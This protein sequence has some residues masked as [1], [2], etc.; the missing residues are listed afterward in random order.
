MIDLPD[1]YDRV[2]CLKWTSEDVYEQEA[3]KNIYTEEVTQG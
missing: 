2:W 3:E 1:I